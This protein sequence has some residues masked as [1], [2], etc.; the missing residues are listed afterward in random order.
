MEDNAFLFSLCCLGRHHYW[1]LS[2]Q[3]KE[4]TFVKIGEKLG[5]DI[6]ISLI[7]LKVSPPCRISAYQEGDSHSDSKH[8]GF[9]GTHKRIWANLDTESQEI[10]RWTD[11]FGNGRQRPHNSFFLRLLANPIYTKQEWIHS[12]Y[13]NSLG[14]KRSCGMFQPS[15]SLM[16]GFMPMEIIFRP[17]Y[18]S[19]LK[20]QWRNISFLISLESET[21]IESL[22]LS[23]ANVC[24]RGKVN[25]LKLYL[26]VPPHP[27]QD[28]YLSFQ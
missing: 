12:F 24:S 27:W 9:Y 20:L 2:Q 25:E 28:N 11:W 7:T 13:K 23:S 6:P 10:L 22:H 17:S 15:G 21:R 1:S 18:Q 26:E 8:C 16:R 4:A 3:K 5:I 19:E 14:N